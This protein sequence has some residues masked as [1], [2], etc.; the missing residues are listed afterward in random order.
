MPPTVGANRDGRVEVLS[1]V[2]EIPAGATHWQRIAAIAGAQRGRTS[3]RQLLAAGLSGSAIDRLLANGCLSREHPGVYVVGHCAVIPGAHETSAL[4]A[5][6][7]G[8][9]LSHG[10]ALIWWE[11]LAATGPDFDR[12]VHVTVPGVAGG[13]PDG[14]IVHRSTIL[15][16]RDLRIRDGLPVTSPARTLLDVAATLAPRELERALDSG[17]VG[18]LLRLRDVTEILGRA[19]RHGGRA[20]LESLV[21]EHTHTT[22][23]RSEAEERFLA[24]VREAGLADP[25]VNV[26]RHG[27]EIDFL[28]P[29]AHVAVEI[30]GY[31]FH[32]SRAAFER[33]RGRDAALRA[34]GLTVVRITWRRLTGSPL[35]IVAE[36]AAMLSGIPRTRADPE[37]PGAPPHRP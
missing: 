29:D 31:A 4:L 10:S 17:L 12:T 6:R 1:D 15:T 32:A 24:L 8:A 16:G 7:R 11:M 25:M 30:D 21:D 19:G 23:T 34:A 14:V 35:A 9:A 28:G 33:D 2:V 3:R 22:F 26:R 13:A 20:T 36:L 18:R 5:V 37:R 27:Y